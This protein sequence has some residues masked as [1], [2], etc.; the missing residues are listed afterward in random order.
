MLMTEVFRKVYY[1]D[2]TCIA[3]HEYSK[4]ISE[5]AAR[6]P[7]IASNHA[8]HDEDKYPIQQSPS[9]QEKFQMMR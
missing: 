9:F 2:M 3:E 5:W 6:L 4:R 1:R 7:R 8:T